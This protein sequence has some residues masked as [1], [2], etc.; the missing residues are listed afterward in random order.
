[1]RRAKSINVDNLSN[2]EFCESGE[3]CETV[4]LEGPSL[5]LMLSAR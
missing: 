4:D 3:Q 2:L 1:M 5:S